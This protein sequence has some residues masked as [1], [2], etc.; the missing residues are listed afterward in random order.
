MLATLI[1]L[2]ALVPIVGTLIGGVLMTLVA[3]TSSWV[4]AVIVLSYYVGYHLFETYVLSPRI[5]RRAV[6]VPPVITIIAVIAGGALFGI[7]GALLAIP[8]A[9]GL[10]LMYDQVRVPRQQRS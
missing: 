3:L 5:M 4:D 10:L 2:L 7:V 8:V 6:E 1:G 9:A